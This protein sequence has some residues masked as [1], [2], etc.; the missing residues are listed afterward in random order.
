MSGQF[1]MTLRCI[2]QFVGA[3][4]NARFGPLGKPFGQPCGSSEAK[5]DS[6]VRPR[7]V[8]VGPR[9]VQEASKRSKRRP[10]GV[11]VGS[12]AV[13]VSPRDVQEVSKRDQRAAKQLY[14]RAC[15]VKKPEP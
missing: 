15:T 2:L 14:M 13:Q 7:A 1:F 3:V 10:R 12:K 4:L 6:Q 5:L 11:Q 8:Q 9:G